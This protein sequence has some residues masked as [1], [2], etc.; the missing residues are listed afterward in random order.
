[1]RNARIDPVRVL[2]LAAGLL[3][4][5]AAQAANGPFTAQQ[6]EDG[7]TKFNNHCAQC[8]RPNLQGATGPALVGDG[9]K[10]KWA[11]KPVADLRTYIHEKM[12][13]N[14]P[15]SLADDQIDPITAYILSKNGVQPGDTPLS[16]D[17][18]N[19]AFPK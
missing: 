6:A 14:T 2:T 19:G 18:A 16:K 8:H 4:A 1:L 5:G 3:A 7:H 15:G 9:F 17:S 11:G 10:D 12:P 13:Q